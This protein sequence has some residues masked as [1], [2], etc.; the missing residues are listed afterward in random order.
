MTGS[1]PNILTVVA[2][3]WAIFAKSAALGSILI[4][5]SLKNN[6]PLS[7]INKFV[8]A[9]LVAPSSSPINFKIGFTTFG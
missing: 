6:G 2:V 4:E 5:V 9:I 3:I 8:V 1:I 7:V